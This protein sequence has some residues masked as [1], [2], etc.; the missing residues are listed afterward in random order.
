MRFLFT[1]LILIVG[2]VLGIVFLNNGHGVNLNLAPFVKPPP[3]PA[4]AY[5]VFP[6]WLVM[7]A[8]AAIGFVLGWLMGVMGR[9]S[10]DSYKP[11]PPPKKQAERDYLVIDTVPDRRS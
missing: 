10:S 6:L 2:F 11:P 9:Y 3:P 1:V 5:R 8:C 7:F 4:T